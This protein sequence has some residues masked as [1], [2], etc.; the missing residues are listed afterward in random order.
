MMGTLNY[1]KPENLQRCIGRPALRT[2]WVRVGGVNER[3]DR[4]AE[5]LIFF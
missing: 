2:T 4:A 1:K 5:V 3:K